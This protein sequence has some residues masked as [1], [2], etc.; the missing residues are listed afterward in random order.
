MKLTTEQSIED[1]GL[2]ILQELGY[3]V[4]YGPDIAPDGPKPER[5]KWDD[6]VLVERLRSAIDKFN[7][8]IPSVAKEEALK[9]VLR[10][11]SHKLIQ[12]NKAFQKYLANGVEVEY[13]FKGRI[14]GDIVQLF[15]FDKPKQNE[16]L[17]INQFTIIENKKNRR[18]DILLFVNGLPIVTIEL[19]SPTNPKATI[20]TA[21]KQLQTYHEDIPTLF[22]YNAFEIISDGK[23][24]R[25]GTL[26]ASYEWFL[27]WR[28]VNGAF[29]KTTSMETTLRGMCDRETI[30][31][32]AKNFLTYTNDN[33]KILAGYHQYNATKKAIQKTYKAIGHNKKIGVV[34]HTQGSGK[35]FTMGFYTALMNKDP[36][37]KNPTIV[38]LTDR[39][40]LDDQLHDTFASLSLFQEP[41][42]KIK[43]QE[44]LKTALKVSSGGIIFTTIQKFLSKNGSTFEEL[45]RR[46][47]IIVVTDEAHRTQYGFKA[48]LQENVLKYGLA[49]YLR[50]ALPN[51]SFIG[52]TGTPI[53]FSDKSTREVFGEYIDIY[54]MHLA[55]EDH[56]VVKIIYDSKLIKLGKNEEIFKQID[57]LIYEFTEQEEKGL[58]EQEKAKWSTIEA[59]AG[60]EPRIR[61]LAKSIINHFEMRQLIGNGKAMVVCMSRRI[62][63]A[64]H[65][66]IKKLRPE[67]YH[68]DDDK[69]IMKVIMT[70]SASD[71]K[72]YLEHTRNKDRRKELAKTFKEPN[73]D[74]KLAIVRD[75]WLTGFDVPCMNTLYIDKIIRHHNLMQTIARVNRVYKD[76]EAGLVI[77]FIGIADELRK[78]VTVY[79][80]TANKDDPLSYGD[81][82]IAILKEKYE[83]VKDMLDGCNY[84]EYYKTKNAKKRMDIFF[85]IE[86]HIL[87]LDDGKKRF[88]RNT[89]AL[90]KSLDL[91]ITSNEA[92]L[93]R[94]DAALF[95]SLSRSLMK[96]ETGKGGLSKGLSDSVIKQLVSKAV[97]AEGEVDVFKHLNIQRPEISILSDKFLETFQNMEYKNLAFETLKKLLADEIRTRFKTNKIA[98]KKFSKMLEEAILKYQNRSI[99]SA[100][101]IALLI[102]QAKQIRVELDRGEELGG[103]T[104]EEIAFYDA[105]ADNDSAKEILGEEVL[106]KIARELSER[107]REKASIDWERRESVRAELRVMVKRLLKKYG[108]PPDKTAMATDLV[109][110]QAEVLSHKWA[111]ED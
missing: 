33:Q 19:K 55:L 83:I 43:S 38:I 32:I 37:L 17:A 46:D 28:T 6:V 21:F 60:S 24:T 56:R 35:S 14:K 52:F 15:N 39:N 78:A 58:V 7:P 18:P 96:T 20:D 97:E 3:K 13:R 36:K 53:E 62:C 88:V 27:P 89:Q 48:K 67:Y 94:E 26:T 109:L 85:K 81:Q 93:I 90:M 84:Q 12:N 29:Q 61:Q 72:E 9:K 80:Q 8:D 22:N 108:Y 99:D 30:L 4:I 49:K 86:E 34:W 106:K 11:T 25:A 75:M 105:L 10:S 110:E 64:L 77:D 74:F 1:A 92:K 111:G 2:E 104:D 47:N 31:D 44:E 73:S 70:G 82:A 54:D 42:K 98:E 87:S 91:A 100:Q 69:G 63:I 103:L 66:E 107:V 45:S 40:D 68:K 59:L 16:F 79:T 57:D 76:K 65:D 101:V 5:A 102:E 95:Q 41:P 50:D 23:D 51:A 71:G